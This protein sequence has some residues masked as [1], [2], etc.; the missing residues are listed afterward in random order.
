[1]D[2]IALC[3]WIQTQLY[4]IRSHI[5]EAFGNEDGLEGVEYAGMVLVAVTLLMAIAVALK[6]NDGGIGTA[7]TGTLSKWI[8]NLG[9]SGPQ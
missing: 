6:S 4:V 5:E 9:N 8:T 1:M 3:A 2:T 7:L